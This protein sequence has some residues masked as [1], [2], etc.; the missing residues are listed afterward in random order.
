MRHT[1]IGPIAGAGGDNGQFL[2]RHQWRRKLEAAARALRE[3]RDGR[4]NS[5]PPLSQL[6]H[7]RAET[8]DREKLSWVAPKLIHPPP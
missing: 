8:E 5:D 2:L 6:S 4:R 7:N 1:R 3:I